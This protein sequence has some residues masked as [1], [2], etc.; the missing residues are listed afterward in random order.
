M[1]HLPYIPP[2]PA[3]GEPLPAPEPEQEFTVADGLE[4]L[5]L[6]QRIYTWSNEYLA[7]R[8]GNPIRSALLAA[9]DAQGTDVTP[10]QVL[11]D[12]GIDPEDPKQAVLDYEKRMKGFDA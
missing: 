1:A 11:S 12:F 9:R 5:G 3:W 4:W 2:I 6:P 7:G 8:H 10:E